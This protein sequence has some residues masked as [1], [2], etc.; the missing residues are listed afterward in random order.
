MEKRRCLS[1]FISKPYERNKWINFFL[2]KLNQ[3]QKKVGLATMGIPSS[4][5]FILDGLNVK[6][7][8]QQI[9][10][11]V[12]VVKGKPDPEIFLKTLDKLQIEGKDA[13]VVEDSI[14]GI[15][16]ALAA[17]IKVVGITTTH[18]KEEL[19][20]NGC[21]QVIDDYSHIEIG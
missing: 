12:E 16:A 14:G 6:R 15:K 8:F 21:F 7:F 18:S 17:G 5:D 2:Q 13:M 19:L 4:I 1:K 11:G 9:T 20:D 3:K 10:G